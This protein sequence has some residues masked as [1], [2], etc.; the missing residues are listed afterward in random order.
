MR[1]RF[2]SHQS[3][4]EQWLRRSP[5]ALRVVYGLCL[6]VVL[7]N[8]ASAQEVAPATRPTREELQSRYENAAKLYGERKWHTAAEEFRW[9]SSQSPDSL[10]GS[11]ATVY[12]AECLAE[13][14]ESE[15]ALS[16]LSNWLGTVAEKIGSEVQ[17]GGGEPSAERLLA[18]RARLRLAD[19]AQRLGNVELSISNYKILAQAAALPDSKARALLALGRFYQSKGDVLQANDFYS[20][21]LQQPELS[22]FHDAARLGTLAL[23]LSGEGSE[24]AIQGL[25]QFAEEE[26]SSAV[27]S[28]AALQLAQFYYS[29]GQFESAVAMYERVI[30]LSSEAAMLPY[31]YMGISN[32]LYQLGRKDEAR[33]KLLQY[34]DQFPTDPNWT[35]QAYQFIRWQLAAGDAE[36]ALQWLERLHDIGFATNEEEVVWLKT[37]SLWGRVSRQFKPAIDALRCAILLSA[38]G[39]KFELQKELLAVLIESGEV[40][41]VDTELLGWISEYKQGGS[42]DSL[43]FFEVKR[44]ELLAQRRD[45]A[46]AGPLVAAWLKENIDHPQKPDVMLVRAQCEIGTSHIEEA[47]VTLNDEVFKSATT[48]D[49]LRAQAMWLIGETYFLQKEY[50]AAV[51]A[52][53]NVVQG[54]QDAKWK[55]LAMLQAGKCYEIVGQTQDAIQLYEEALK[56]SPAES[57]KKQIEGRL[58]EARQTRTSSLT[59]ANKN[60]IPSR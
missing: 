36:G 11:Y 59:P 55:A 45:W 40:A 17:G 39:E 9:L 34:L 60:T 25:R 51:S 20:Q 48:A 32:S 58:G 18:D 54:F 16:L 19:L 30:A 14:G 44:L 37:K 28:P 43:M 10:L 22:A 31:A 21:V 47:R 4:T 1:L 6:F 27:S 12:E 52:Y 3:E 8:G 2:F 5:W 24:A 57:V 41:T 38:E 13:D 15:R 46:T 49:R 29:K 50:V 26:P 33:Q 42:R 53:S 7:V 56:L 23:Q 35:Q